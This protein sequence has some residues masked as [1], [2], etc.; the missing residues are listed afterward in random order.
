[1]RGVAREPCWLATITDLEIQDV[2]ARHAILADVAT[3]AP[4]RLVTATAERLGT[5]A[6]EYYDS[7]SVVIPRMCEAPL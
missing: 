5:F 7:D 1:M 2:E 6:S 3:R 4:Y